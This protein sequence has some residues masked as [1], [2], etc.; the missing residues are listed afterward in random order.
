MMMAETRMRGE[1]QR[2]IT[3]SVTLVG[4]NIGEIVTFFMGLITV[5]GALKL[6]PFCSVHEDMV[7]FINTLFIL[8][9]M[10]I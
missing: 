8:P 6:M 9:C 7:S 5:A 10:S 3:I 4:V 2:E 1:A